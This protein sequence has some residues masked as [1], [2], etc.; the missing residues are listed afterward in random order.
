M[1]FYPLREPLFLA[2]N[3]FRGAVAQH[4]HGRGP[5]KMVALARGVMGNGAME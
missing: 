3:K 1:K 2:Q 5:A 4:G